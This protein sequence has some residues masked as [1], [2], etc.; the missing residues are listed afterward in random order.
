MYQYKAKQLKA[1]TN[2]ILLDFC[3]I[4]G[5]DINDILNAND[6]EIFEISDAEFRRF[7]E[8]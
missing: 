3:E 8:V 6:N 7:N 1:F 5:Y 4:T 2:N